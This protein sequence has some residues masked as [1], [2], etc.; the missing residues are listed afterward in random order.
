VVWEGGEDQG[1]RYAYAEPPAG[2]AI[3]ELTARTDALEGLAELI[4]SA[5]ADWDGSDPIRELGG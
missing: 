4:R 3:A 1:Q 2:A 5:A